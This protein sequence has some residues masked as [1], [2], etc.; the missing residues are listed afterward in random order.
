[1]GANNVEKD[2]LDIKKG[3]QDAQSK[4]STS[5]TLSLL[6][7]LSKFTM[8]THEDAEV[9][10]LAK[11]IVKDWK[12][13]VAN[14]TAPASTSSTPS[15]TAK[16]EG[17]K[18]GST[19]KSSAAQPTVDTKVASAS[20]RDGS[21]TASSPQTPT[22][23]PKDRTIRSDGVRIKPTGNEVRDKCIEMLYQALGT[24]SYAESE[25]LLQKSVK[26]EEVVF[27]KLSPDNTPSKAYRER[28]RVFFMNLRKN[29]PELRDA[30]VSGEV[31]VEDFCNYTPADM[32][33]AESKARDRAMQLENMFKAKGA[34][35]QQ[36]ETDMFKCGKCKGRKCRYYQMQTRSADEPMTTFVTCINC[37]NR[38][39]F[40]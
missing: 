18:S 2:M 7:Q 3:L 37:G 31:A 33:T 35:E 28:I 29:N 8:K 34:E 9:S 39:K 23:A 16:S 21:S 5:Q 11:T 24:N 20:S 27:K 32:A 26:I 14:E 10:K 4:G 36:A 38:W 25:R 19:T 13:Q 1:M 17:S 15:S 6:K 22:D 12:T 30:V 40:S